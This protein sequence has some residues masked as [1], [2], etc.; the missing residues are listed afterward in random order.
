M[1]WFRIL[2]RNITR[3]R[4]ISGKLN[5]ED[6]VESS[7]F[8]LKRLLI[9]YRVYSKFTAAFIDISNLGMVMVSVLVLFLFNI[10]KIDNTLSDFNNSKI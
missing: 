4:S 10:Y 9:L 8:H 7:C 5:N 1:R 3:L 6:I 2:L